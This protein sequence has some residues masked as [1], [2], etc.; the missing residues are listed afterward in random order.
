MEIEETSFAV[1]IIQVNN[2]I[3]TK[4]TEILVCFSLFFVF[5][6]AHE[7]SD[8]LIFVCDETLPEHWVLRAS[9]KTHY[10]HFDLRQIFLLYFV[11]FLT[12]L[13]NRL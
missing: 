8:L 2:H 6:P 13:I 7:V 3:N 1:Q 12:L 9:M 5:L 11:T 10:L 4:L